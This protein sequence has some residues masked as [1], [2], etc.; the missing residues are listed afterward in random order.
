MSTDYSRLLHDIRYVLKDE[1][2]DARFPSEDSEP[3]ISNTEMRILDCL[4]PQPGAVGAKI[5]REAL[6]TRGSTYVLLDRLTNKGLIT[7]TTENGARQYSVTPLGRRLYRAEL[8]AR[9]ARAMALAGV[10]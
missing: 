2:D 7:S 6:V 9:A 4:E 1:E 10:P 8:T 5:C 3:T